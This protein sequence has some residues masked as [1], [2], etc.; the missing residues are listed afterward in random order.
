MQLCVHPQRL[1]ASEMRIGIKYHEHICLTGISLGIYERV[2]CLFFRSGALIPTVKLLECVK[3]ES[4]T[5][6]AVYRPSSSF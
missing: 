3:I 2:F 6:V 1:S 5:S 4:G